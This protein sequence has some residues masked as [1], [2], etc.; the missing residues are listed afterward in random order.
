MISEHY[1]KKISKEEINL[2]PIISF[3]GQIILCDSK[4]LA[5]HSAKKL[6]KEKVIGFDTETKPSFKKGEYYLPSLLQLATEEKVYLF[7]IKKCSLTKSLIKIF[8][9]KKILKV[10]IALKHDIN[11]LQ[12][13]KYFD[14]NG[15]IDL[16]L[17][18][19]DAGINNLGLKS[20]V[21][22]FMNHKLSKKEQVS[23]WA[24]ENLSE[25][26]KLYAATDAWLSKKLYQNF[27]MKGLLISKQ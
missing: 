24:K 9:S 14:S 11:E 22:I 13:I 12:K 26:Q 6:L 20:L 1:Q 2:L 10:G 5:E 17:I 7:Q 23:N 25:S 18:A 3:S 27:E 19:K 15:F 21:A 4:E 16:S 8:N